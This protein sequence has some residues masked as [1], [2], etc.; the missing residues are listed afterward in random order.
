MVLLVFN[1]TS[2]NECILPNLRNSNFYMPIYIYTEKRK[3]LLNIR[4]DVANGKWAI[5]DNNYV[6]MSIC[7][8]RV[9]NHSLK[10][11]DMID[12]Q[13]SGKHSL[14]L[15]VVEQPLR[16]YVSRKVLLEKHS[17]ITVGQSAENDIRYQFSTYVNKVQAV[18]ENRADGLYIDSCRQYG[19]YVN[20]KSVEGRKKL[21]IGDKIQIFGLNIVYLSS[22]LA[23]Y[24]SIGEPYI[25]KQEQLIYHTEVPDYVRV[26]EK[27]NEVLFNRSPR[28]H[29]EI[30]SEQIQIEGPPRRLEKKV[31]PIFLTVGPAFTM[32][33]PMLLGSLAVM[34]SMR[35]AHQKAG[36]F[37]Y[38][39]IIIA[40]S[41][42]IIGTVWAVLNVLYSRQEQMD[43][44]EFR[45]R[46]YAEYLS[47]IVRK[48]QGYYEYNRKALHKTYPSAEQCVRYNQ[49][50]PNLWTRNHTHGDMLF[51]RLGTGKV[52]FQVSVDIPKETFDL[53]RDFL[54][55]KPQKIKRQFENLTDVPIGISLEKYQLIGLVGGSGN[56]KRRC[57]DLM[58]IISVQLASNLCYTDLKL[59]Y[60]YD[61]SRGD[62]DRDWDFYRWYPHVWSED[63]HIRFIAGDVSERRDVFFELTDIMRKRFQNSEKDDN[64]NKE[65]LPHYVLFIS[66]SEILRGE[67]LTNYLYRNGAGIG[68]TAFLMAETID[69]LPNACEYVIQYDQNFCGTYSLVDREETRVPVKFDRVSRALVEVQARQL[70]FVKVKEQEISRTIPTSIS[71]LGMYGVDCPEKL[72]IKE[73]WTKNRTYESLGVPI[74]R[75]NDNLNI[76]LDIHEKY[77]GPHGLIAGTTGSGKSEMLQTFILSLAVNFGPE[78]LSFLLIDF[79]GG[80]MANLF[81]SLPHLAGRITNLSG[82]EIQRAMISITSENERRERVF[83]KYR[84]NHI[85]EYTV[86]YKNGEAAVPIPHLLIIIDEFAELKK[87]N[88]GFMNELISVA[89]VGRSLGVHLILATQKP[90]GIVDDSIMSNSR[91]RICL[92]VQ[93]RQDSLDMLHRPDAAFITQVGRGYFQVGADEIYELFQS[94]YSGERF[95]R[96]DLYRRENIEMITLT[97]KKVIVGSGAVKR[98][99]HSESDVQ[100]NRKEMRQL[101]AV[102]EYIRETAVQSGFTGCMQLWLPPL[103]SKIY[104]EEVEAYGGWNALNEEGLRRFSLSA[105]IGLCDDPVNQRQMPLTLDFATGGNHAV[106]GA[107]STGK[108]TLLLTAAY[109]FL[110]HYDSIDLNLYVLD[111]SSHLLSALA[112]SDAVGGVVIDSDTE[113]I[114]R[115]VSMLNKIHAER[116]EQ[117]SGGSFADYSRLTQKEMPAIVVIIDNIGAALSKFNDR[118][119]DDIVRLIREGNTCGIFFFV[120]ATGIN[121]NDLPQSLAD[122]FK[123]TLSLE[124]SEKFKYMETLRIQKLPILPEH[125]VRGRG[126][127]VLNGRVLEFQTAVPLKAESEY[128][129]GNT[130]RQN[131]ILRNA[132]YR[133]QPAEPIPELPKKPSYDELILN[134]EY[135]KM[136]QSKDVLPVGWKAEDASLYGI[137]LRDTYCYTISGSARTGKTTFMKT[138]ILTAL[139]RGT[140]TVVIEPEGNCMKSFSEQNAVSYYNGKEGMLAFCQMIAPVFK[141]RNR[142]K[143]ELLKNGGSNRVIFDEVN[144]AQIFVFITDL[145][146]FAK[147]AELSGS[148][149]MAGF[150]ENIFTK[151]DLHGI[152]FIAELRTDDA[153]V[154]GSYKLF[155]I[156]TEY[157]QGIHLGGKISTL[158]FYDFSGVR[159]TEQVS[160]MKRGTGLVRNPEDETK[161]IRIIVPDLER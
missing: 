51:V 12:L 138:V 45:F 150:L 106:F 99:D 104:L 143:Q 105:D 132:V 20:G 130:I 33:I 120:S 145:F 124:Q 46:E 10:S 57:L 38:T 79:K 81:A 55:D 36:A 100:M 109:S 118:Q 153:T 17:R 136:V 133:G 89:Q 92:R 5:Y 58:N 90:S 82:N 129:R 61:R 113:R 68:F 23:V 32:A 107:G 72:Q 84:V 127:A 40:V 65:T 64:R 44:E 158:R 93:E 137:F 95:N 103:S 50:N 62:R 114:D 19:T 77:H 85:D 110:M 56:S 27:K 73:R 115:F 24:S 69:Q 41:S 125:G 156:F 16:L 37:M 60:I 91:F 102:V 116:K 52:P 161:A 49:N 42:A 148:G 87:T 142:I 123:T 11:G 8:I 151:G 25:L 101:D 152:Y 122:Y 80:G 1:K 29:R 63:R 96:G 26:S 21:T 119:K 117:L 71:F 22:L 39:G 4:L 59:A 160:P 30:I 139:R 121:I 67:I 54:F 6:E 78:D 83:A 28:E 98:D 141:E 74:G 134:R 108:S 35:S 66:D 2:Y 135:L 7:G 146:V 88:A 159:M 94:A 34:Y 13:V 9:R 18:L 47:R 128:E 157:R 154:G 76:C 86:L 14:K 111:Y 48:L 140:Q 144:K 3:E 97:G 112:S 149:N 53:N 31:Q 155:R 126:L 15:L 75:K 70:S 131:L 43:E 147:T